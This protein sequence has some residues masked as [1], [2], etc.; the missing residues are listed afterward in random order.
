MRRYIV[1]AALA[2]SLA[3]PGHAATRREGDPGYLSC[4]CICFP[5]IDGKQ[6]CMCVCET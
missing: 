4:F 1:L 5:P 2:L 3:L 6:L